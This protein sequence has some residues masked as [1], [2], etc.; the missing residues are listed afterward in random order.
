MSDKIKDTEKMETKNLES[1]P[2]ENDLPNVKSKEYYEKLVTERRMNSYEMRKNAQEA[3]QKV[4]AEDL[5]DVA[6]GKA[7][8]E[9]PVPFYERYFLKKYG[10]P[11]MYDLNPNPLTPEEQKKLE[12]ERKKIE[13][14]KK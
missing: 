9:G 2:C 7:F 1:I 13:R 8:C 12:E 5:D 14:E 10:G 6:G 4:S 3:T 11:D